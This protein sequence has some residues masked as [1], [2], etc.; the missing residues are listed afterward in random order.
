M[1]KLIALAI[2]SVV[3]VAPSW[4]MAQEGYGGDYNHGQ[5][6]IFADYFR[7][8]PTSSNTVNWVGFGARTGFNVS[9]HTQL[10]AEMFLR[11]PA[12]F[13]HYFE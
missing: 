2:L 3:M 7:F 8:S 11:L 6:G 4:V 5:V 1:K 10:E 9:H 13:H 12:Q